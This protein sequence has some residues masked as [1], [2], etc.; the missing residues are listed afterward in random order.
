MK[1]I[2]I[3]G[4]VIVALFAILIV[5]VQMQNKEASEGNPYG[6]ETLHPKTIEQLDDPLY[7]NQ[8]LPDE[9]EAKLSNGEDVTVYF[10]SPI[11]P[12]CQ[13]VTPILVPLAEEYDIDLKKLNVLEFEEAW[14]EYG[15]NGTPTLIHFENGEE[16]ARM[17]G[18]NEED[19]FRLFLETEVLG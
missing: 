7:Q 14:D 2:L 3:F 1:K 18:E 16:A 6:K 19:V 12:H 10:Y 5:V 11:C 15:I 9:L 8:I 17:E 13:R 4:A